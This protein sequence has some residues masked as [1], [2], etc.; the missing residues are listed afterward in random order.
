MPQARAPPQ[1]AASGQ[2]PTALES[3]KRCRIKLGPPL[4]P[5][6]SLVTLH[7]P[8]SIVDPSLHYL[9]DHHELAEADVRAFLASFLVAC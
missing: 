6:S 3:V 5:V 1:T 2:A 8:L 7:S 9:S 4:N